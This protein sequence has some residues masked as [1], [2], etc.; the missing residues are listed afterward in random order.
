MYWEGEAL[1]INTIKHSESAL[2]VTLFA[3]DSIHK[4]YAKGANSKKNKAIYQIGNLITT[5]QKSRSEHSL[6]NLTNTEIS[7]NYNA[8]FINSNKN[9][10]ILKTITEFLSLALQDNENYNILFDLTI[11]FLEN[12]VNQEINISQYI[13]YELNFLSQIGYGIALSHCAVSQTTEN[14]FYVSPNTGH[15]VT[16]KIGEKYHEK[17]LI[18]PQ[19]LRQKNNQA[20]ITD[21]EIYQA[22]NLTGFF[23]SKH[24]LTP[25]NKKLPYSRNLLLKEYIK[26]I[27]PLEI[28]GPTG[29]EPTRYGDWEKNGR[30]SDF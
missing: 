25:F 11:D 5:V 18:I 10:L 1:L 4:S 12:A 6:G 26:N 16:K 27:A 24:I 21:T 13:N 8:H 17:L 2:I 29:A 19:F 28:G 7:K 9:T 20:E 15:A 22:F 23:I 14:L 30:V 3:R